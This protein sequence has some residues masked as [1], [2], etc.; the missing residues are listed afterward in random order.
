MNPGKRGAEVSLRGSDMKSLLLDFL[1]ASRSSIC[2]IINV[3]FTPATAKGYSQAARFP[4]C[5]FNSLSKD[6]CV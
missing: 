5:F 6:V 3:I 2:M 1:L 4:P